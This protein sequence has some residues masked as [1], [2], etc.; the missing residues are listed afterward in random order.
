MVRT[1]IKFYKKLYLKLTFFLSSKKIYKAPPKKKIL[2]YDRLGSDILLN[3]LDPSNVEIL[4][5]RGES[6]NL[7]ILL[8]TLFQKNKNINYY[9]YYIGFVN[10]DIIITFCDNNINFY[11][12]KNVYPNIV[13]L[14]I[15]NGHRQIV[16]D[17]FETL[18]YNSLNFIVDHMFCFGD[19]ICKE[20][21]KYID[22]NLYSIG[23]FRNNILKIDTNKQLNSTILFISQFREESKNSNIFM[24]NNKIS[25]TREQFY[26]T[27]TILLPILHS[28]CKKYRYRLQ[29]C[30]FMSNQTNKEKDYYCKLLN[31]IDW[32]FYPRNNMFDSYK[33]IDNADCVVTVDSTLGYEALA[34][35]KKVA[36]FSCRGKMLNYEGTDF[37]WPLLIQKKGKFW[38]DEI[39]IEEFDRIMKYM[40]KISK[41]DWI[42]SHTD[43]TNRIITYDFENK[44]FVELMKN[45]NIIKQY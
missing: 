36:F 2:I 21:S 38:T 39:T 15:Q 43:I 25:I 37:A 28:F 34:R 18:T 8:K 6:I 31:D 12:I 42:K 23:S 40:I 41:H 26:C 5:I 11:K 24:E 17:I 20:Y 16:G 1:F 45:L 13:T 30:G 32:D 7:I 22:G 44:K 33:L 19:A 35:N 4:D 10:P 27:E 14:F 29:I 9:L 3:Y